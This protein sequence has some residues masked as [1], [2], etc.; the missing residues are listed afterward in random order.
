MSSTLPD[1]Y[2]CVYFTLGTVFHQESGDLLIRVPVGLC[3]LPLD[4]VVTVGREINPGE[5]GELLAARPAT[6]RRGTTGRR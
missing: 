4:V 2:P 1:R 3:D 6:D 5:L